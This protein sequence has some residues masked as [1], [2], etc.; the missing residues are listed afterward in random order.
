M[1]QA[2]PPLEFIPPAFNPLLLKLVHLVLP[3]WILSQTLI[4]N[5]EADNVKILTDSY[6]RFQDGKIRFMMAF[7]HPQTTDPLCL[8]YLFSQILP[9]V[10]RVEGKQLEYPLH[11]HFIYDRGIPVAHWFSSGLGNFPFKPLIKNLFASLREKL[12]KILII[13]KKFRIFLRHRLEFFFSSP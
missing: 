9:K 2:Q 10:A 3:S 11:A 4:N 7:C 6:R 8:T 5:I 12:L 1:Y 13:N